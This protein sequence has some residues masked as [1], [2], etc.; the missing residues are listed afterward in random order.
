M[1]WARHESRADR[2]PLAAFEWPLIARL[3]LNAYEAVVSNQTKDRE[4]PCVPAV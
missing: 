1:D 3:T 4:R 2:A